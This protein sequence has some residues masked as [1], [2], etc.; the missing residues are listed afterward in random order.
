LD[1]AD[2]HAGEVEDQV[3]RR[4]GQADRDEQAVDRTVPA[5]EV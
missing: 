4:I 2:H 1:H 5:Q 3:H